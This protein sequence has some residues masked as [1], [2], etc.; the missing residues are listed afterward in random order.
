MNFITR[1]NVSGLRL[2]VHTG[3]AADY[4][5]FDVGA[6]AGKQWQGG[7]AFLSYSY[8]Q[9]DPLFGRDR[10]FVR[11]FPSNIAGIPFPVKS[12]ACS[13]GNVQVQP[14]GTVYALP[15]SV[16]IGRGGHC[17]PVRRKRRV[18]RSIPENASI[19]CSQA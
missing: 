14:A 3:F 12:V 15:Y 19:R 18:S 9:H 10:D 11:R 8:V 7:S 4:R 1:R 2:D 5:S 6:T 16:R 13:P 17:Q